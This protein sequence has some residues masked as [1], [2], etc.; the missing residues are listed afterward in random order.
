MDFDYEYETRI[1]DPAYFIKVG[2]PYEG[3]MV[4]AQALMETLDIRGFAIIGKFYFFTMQ[5]MRQFMF[6]WKANGEI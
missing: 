5:D 1:S 4:K 2:Y 6:Y 3:V